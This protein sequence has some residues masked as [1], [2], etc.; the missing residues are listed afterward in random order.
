MTDWNWIIHVHN[1]M[2]SVQRGD[3]MVPM[4]CVAEFMLGITAHSFI[5][6]QGKLVFVDI[7]MSWKRFYSFIVPPALVCFLIFFV[8]FKRVHSATMNKKAGWCSRHAW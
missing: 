6:S 5:G 3:V 8:F 4:I 2:V 7:I 1:E